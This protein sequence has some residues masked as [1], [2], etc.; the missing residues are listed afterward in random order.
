MK[1]KNC[2]YQISACAIQYVYFLILSFELPLE[3]FFLYDKIYKNII[4]HSKNF[5]FLFISA[6]VINMSV[7]PLVFLTDFYH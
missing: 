6:W 4:S 5:D 2:S 3:I 1:K 7:I